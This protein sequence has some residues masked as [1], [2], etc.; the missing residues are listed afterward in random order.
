[1]P[2]M[3]IITAVMNLQR[4]KLQSIKVKTRN[5][6][7]KH[8]RLSF[9][10]YNSFFLNAVEE[11]KLITTKITTTIEDVKIMFEVEYTFAPSNI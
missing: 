9:C 3:F 7:G 8:N 11:I 6:K 10:F 5:K 4:A 2:T 1:M